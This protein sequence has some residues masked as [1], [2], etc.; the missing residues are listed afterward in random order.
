MADS[1]KQPADEG[2]NLAETADRRGNGGVV[3]WSSMSHA[4]RIAKP[5]RSFRLRRLS[6]GLGVAAVVLVTGGRVAGA[7]EGRNLIAAEGGFERP[8]RVSDDDRL[9]GGWLRFPIDG[10]SRSLFSPS[11]DVVHGGEHAQRIEVVRLMNGS[12]RLSIPLPHGIERGMSYEAAAW[13]RSRKRHAVIKICV[14]DAKHWFPRNHVASDRAIGQDWT[15]VAMRFTAAETDAT[16]HFGL[17]VSE[18]NTVWVDDA[19]FRRLVDEPPS[20]VAKDDGGRVNKLRNASFEVG[21][22]A[23]TMCD[24]RCVV[25]EIEKAPH[26]SRVA[27]VA[28]NG[29]PNAR[30]ESDG[31]R[32]RAG[33]PYTLS[34]T[35]RAKKAGSRSRI[36]VGAGPRTIAV[37]EFEAPVGR[38]ERVSLTF[39]AEHSPDETAYVSIWPPQ[40]SEIEVDAVQLEAGADQTRFAPKYEIESSLSLIGHSGGPAWCVPGVPV[41]ATLAVFNDGAETSLPMRH[42]IVDLWDRVV[43]GSAGEFVCDVPAGSSARRLTL[44]A[45]TA[46]TGAFR[47]ECSATGTPGGLPYAECLLSVFPAASGTVA[48]PLGV[49]LDYNPSRTAAYRAAG[50]GWNKTWLL[51]WARAQPAA[52]AALHVSRLQEERV[53]AWG[54][55][56]I[57][58]LGILSNAPRWAQERT[59]DWGWA[60]P[61]D[62]DAMKRYA[63]EVV[64]HFGGR[65][66]IWELQNEPNQELHP[67]TKESRAAGYAA[68]AAALAAGARSARDD[69]KLLLGSLTVRDEFGAFFDEIFASQ[70]ALAARDSATG[71]PRLHGVSFHF[72]TA[73]P[74]I[75]RRSVADIR[76]ALARHGMD[77]IAIWDTEW[78]LIDNCRSMK[79]GE[80]RG[81]T[82]HSPG[83]R[84]AAALVVQGFIARLGEGVEGAVLYDT[85]NPGGMAQASHKTMLELDGSFTPVA[86]AVAVLAAELDGATRYES[87]DWPQSWAYRVRRTGRP[88]VIVAW[89]KDSVPGGMPLALP[90]QRPAQFRDMMGNQLP[91]DDQAEGVHLPD[92]PVYIT[93]GRDAVR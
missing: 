59:T 55:A 51:D 44:L 80:R 65:V 88:A 82:I 11:R 30:I 22:V 5:V 9:A 28:G 20:S 45:A 69:V 56:G 10:I 50:F 53:Q 12:P 32:I 60:A 46:A 26:G 29:V 67:R 66:S 16:A 13:V 35:A 25:R 78:A 41:G 38:W 52:D 43:P 87:L 76:G 90:F 47:A 15:R 19:S 39:T 83:P 48:G 64:G 42:R 73:D 33:M 6:I 37:H 58:T 8:W 23:W 91:L 36:G 79:R 57:Q 71:R 89:R 77:G 68:E 62:L 75:I 17:V 74:A 61:R 34:L 70:P 3:P 4:R 72:Y 24:G 81:V 54:A 86:A 63:S 92:E 1:A 93:E 49:T 7:A 18:E 31:I 14:H 84:R 27:A 21:D 85:Y 2:L 40:D